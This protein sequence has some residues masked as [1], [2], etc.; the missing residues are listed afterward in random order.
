MDKDGRKELKMVRGQYLGEEGYGIVE[1]LKALKGRVFFNSRRLRWEITERG[2]GVQEI[3]PRTS[4]GSQGRR[5]VQSPSRLRDHVLAKKRPETYI[6]GSGGSF[7]RLARK[8]DG[9]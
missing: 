2:E 5:K 4:R 3:S 6:K 9:Y 8:E 1:V 7:S